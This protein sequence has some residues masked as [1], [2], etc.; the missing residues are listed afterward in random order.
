MPD[1]CA[2]WPD[3]L[4][5]EENIVRL[6][7]GTCSRI[8]IPVIN[9]TVHDIDLPPLGRIQ[10]VKAVYPAEVRP[11]TTQRESTCKTT[12]PTMQS[13][14]LKDSNVAQST[15]NPEVTLTTQGKC[16]WDPPVFVD[17]LMPKQQQKVKQLLREE[18][19]G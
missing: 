14:P 13:P 5:V 19:R 9:D 1:E 12:T 16:L 11:V 7:R 3:G 2:W 8:C 17:H 4:R 6:Q 15:E 18:S 10:R